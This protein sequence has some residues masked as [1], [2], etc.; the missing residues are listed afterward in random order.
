MVVVYRTKSAL[1][2]TPGMHLGQELGYG[3]GCE[4]EVLQEGLELGLLGYHKARGSVCLRIAY[5]IDYSIPAWP[6]QRNAECYD[7]VLHHSHTSPL[8]PYTPFSLRFLQPCSPLL[9]LPYG[10]KALPPEW[11]AMS[12]R[13]IYR[14]KAMS[15]RLHRFITIGR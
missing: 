8:S 1:L 11:K 4:G 5:G 14:L 9:M 13:G 7:D 2:G 12:I 15:F 10:G 6:C 3:F